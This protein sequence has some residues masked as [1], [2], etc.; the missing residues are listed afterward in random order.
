MFDISGRRWP[1]GGCPLDGIG[2]AFP[3]S[4]NGVE[5][6]RLSFDLQP[7]PD[8]GK[9]ISEITRALIA[10][11]GVGLAPLARLGEGAM[12]A[13]ARTAE[14]HQSSLTRTLHS[15]IVKSHECFTQRWC[16][17]GTCIGGRQRLS[18]G[19]KHDEWRHV[20]LRLD[21]W[22][23]RLLDAYP[24]GCRSSHLGGLGRQAKWQVIAAELV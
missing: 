22:I 16:P 1:A 12:F 23:R 24:A 8:N 21:G 7:E 11:V 17:S 14:R 20:G 15:S 9:S 5:A 3:P 2:R 6:A 10:R 18:P 19:W 13:S 4:R